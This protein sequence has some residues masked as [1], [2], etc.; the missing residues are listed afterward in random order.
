MATD[1]N[2]HEADRLGAEATSLHPCPL[3]GS[4]HPNQTVPWGYPRDKM[5]GRS[6]SAFQ[7]HRTSKL[8]G[9]DS[10]TKENCTYIQKAVNWL[11]MFL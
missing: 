9:T 11:L 10:N 8:K 7:G 4:P 6:L 2:Q 1:Q 5:T 3:A